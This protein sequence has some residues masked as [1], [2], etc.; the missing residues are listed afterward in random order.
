[1]TTRKRRGG[2]FNSVMKR[3]DRSGQAVAQPNKDSRIQARK[4]NTHTRAHARTIHEH[5]HTHTPHAHTHTHT[6]VHKHKH[7][8]T[9][10]HT[11]TPTHARAHIH[12]RAHKKVHNNECVGAQTFKQ[13]VRHSLSQPVTQ[14]QT[15]NKKT[16]TR[17]GKFWEDRSGGGRER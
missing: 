17:G 3:I 10:T 9:R 11:H 8:H 5:I 6:H 13:I 1:M 16:K 7:T 15:T 12:T 14:T 2:N 4:D